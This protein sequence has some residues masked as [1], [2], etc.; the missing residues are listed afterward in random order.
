MPDAADERIKRAFDAAVQ[1]FCYAD[2]IEAQEDELSNMLHHLGRLVD[3]H[4]ETKRF[5]AKPTE[6]AH[7]AAVMLYRHKDTH[8][9][10]RLAEFG[11]VFNDIF[12]SIFGCLIWTPSPEIIA[13]RRFASYDA[14][15]LTGKPA[16]D[17]TVQAF[18]AVYAAAL[19]DS[20]EL[21][22][23]ASE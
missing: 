10:V 23:R 4:G 14:D 21:P 8:E 12:T 5:A 20:N 2:T 22:R 13:D 1:R 19:A 7:V 11:D 3:R 6:H 16:L 17:T 18:H 9:S 15:Y